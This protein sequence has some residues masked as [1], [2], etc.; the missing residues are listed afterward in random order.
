MAK[1]INR[2]VEL[3]LIE[4]CKQYNKEDSLIINLYNYVEDTYIKEDILLDRLLS[5]RNS[6][7][8]DLNCNNIAKMDT[9]CILCKTIII[10]NI[11]DRYIY[12]N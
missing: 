1:I 12:D 5:T 6:F 3:K 9:T 2:K 7:C 4:I 8:K 11:Y 10:K